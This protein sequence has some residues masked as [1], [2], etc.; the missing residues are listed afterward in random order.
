MNGNIQTVLTRLTSTCPI[1]YSGANSPHHIKP[2]SSGGKDESRNKVWLCKRCHDIVEM[3]H[4]EAGLEY[5]P[6]LVYH[7]RKEFNLGEPVRAPLT[8]PRYG[9][10]RSRKSVIR[11]RDST[12]VTTRWTNWPKVGTCA[13]CGHEFERTRPSQAVCLGC[14]ENQKR[15]AYRHSKSIDSSSY[16][17]IEANIFKA[18]ALIHS[19]KYGKA[20]AFQAYC[21]KC[22]VP[23]IPN[24]RKQGE[25]WQMDYCSYGCWMDAQRAYKEA[26]D[27]ARLVREEAIAARQKEYGRN[28][29]LKHKARREKHNSICDS[30]FS[31]FLT[32]TRSIRATLNSLEHKLV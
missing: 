32:K 19:W 28:N 22:G 11:F 3:M 21:I 13:L 26:D 6:A 16:L 31:D 18:R 7:I 1:C 12:T 23:F 17:S 15:F 5:S 25:Q 20:R 8:R 24:L 27:E 4:D 29:Y 30:E 2:L 10:L 9:T 14:I